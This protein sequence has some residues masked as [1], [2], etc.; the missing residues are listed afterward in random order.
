MT[1]NYK[2]IEEE[3]IKRYGTDDWYVDVLSNMYS[4]KTHFIFELIQNADDAFAE[5]VTIK[6][7]KDRIEFIHN[8]KKLFDEENVRGICGL[9]KG[10]KR[11]SLTQIGKFGLGFKSVYAYTDEP[12][13][14]SGDEAFK[15]V[16]FV[17]PNRIEPLTGLNKN[18]T[19][20][21]L[22]FKENIDKNTAFKEIGVKII[23]LSLRTLLFLRNVKSINWSIEG[24]VPLSGKYEKQ[25]LV[26]TTFNN[27]YCLSSNNKKEYW[28]IFK[29]PV[30]RSKLKENGN[31]DTLYV[32]AA[33]QIELDESNKIKS[34]LS[35]EET[36]LVVFFPT[37]KETHLKFLVQGPYRTTH[38]RENIPP[39]DAWN[40][41]LIR[42]TAELIKKT[43]LEF[44]N[45]NVL[46]SN[47]LEIFP[48]D[49]TLFQENSMFLPFYDT[50][51]KLILSG[52]EILPALK[53]YVG[54]NNALIARG[55]G[56]KELL[57]SSQLSD[58]FDEEN[59]KWLHPSITLDRT[60]LL[61]D[62]L[63]K[64]IEIEVITPEKFISAISEEFMEKQTD[65]WI[66]N[67]YCFGKKQYSLTKEGAFNHKPILR[68]ENNQH[69]NPFDEEDSVQVY[70]PSNSYMDSFFD[71]VKKSLI[72]NAEA[73]SFLKE[74]GLREG[75][76]ILSFRKAILPRYRE[77][78]V[79]VKESDNEKHVKMLKLLMESEPSEELNELISGI[80]ELPFFIGVNISLN[81]SKFCKPKN[82]YIGKDYT[83][84]DELNLYFDGNP[85]IYFLSQSYNSIL[86]LE[87][88]K[89][90]G[91]NDKIIVE[92]K[93]PDWNGYVKVKDY[94]GRHKRGLDGFDPDCS[95]EGLSF[96]IE[97]I[98]IEKARI[99]WT[100]LKKYV[101]SIKGTVESSRY[102]TFSSSE[103]KTANSSMGHIITTNAWLPDKDGNFHKPAELSL[104]EIHN[105]LDKN[106]DDAK[107]L[108]NK[109]MKSA[110]I[111]E[112]IGKLPDDEK[113]EYKIFKS[114]REVLTIDEMLEIIK[115]KT[116]PPKKHPEKTY[117]E[118][119]EKDFSPIIQ[120]DSGDVFF[121][122]I[123]K[124]SLPQ[125]ER[126]GKN[127][128]EIQQAIAEKES[129]EE[130]RLTE[131]TRTPITIS[132]DVKNSLIQEYDGKCQI[133]FERILDRKNSPHL[134]MCRIVVPSQSNL[135]I[136]DESNMLAL[137]PN[138]HL[139]FKLK[140]WNFL[141]DG[142]QSR[143][144]DFN[145]SD[146]KE[147]DD[148]E[149]IRI[150]IILAGKERFIHYKKD[151]FDKFR[152]L[153][154]EH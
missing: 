88:L 96:A 35:T 9:G 49:K 58:L 63:T 95:I 8:G 59:M 47:L 142:V 92:Y 114:L 68:L 115:K 126:E 30:D 76:K 42:L 71:I 151:H 112:V 110:K 19:Y 99:I 15:I 2:D 123:T 82:L 66:I 101:K 103:K 69:K 74:L 140:T 102:T 50:V 128:E 26:N 34:F 124:E 53:G 75:N 129:Q 29:E 138:C 91:C 113:E 94:W 78:E 134:S 23:N 31:N 117:E 41:D 150:K 80:K 121:P 16:K 18:L 56:L 145:N 13:I 43:I 38:N 45:K 149:Y 111:E 36:P 48:I 60:R 125:E 62:Y 24:D 154:K 10:T 57:D 21:K 153:C 3:N 61:W 39:D 132:N 84:S 107:S 72:Q 104:E 67:L 20:F 106:S 51:K 81:K 131:I 122:T 100:Y 5:E 120:E 33:F 65:E 44:K 12:I 105:S 147:I 7:F 54:C 127:E 89:R 85:S 116:E 86:S 17:R 70:L 4:D 146:K 22:P 109:I 27:T 77:I 143:N 93:E 98:T 52:E 28:L 108:A 118:E 46:D 133:C 135:G 130:K 11:D 83:N 97:H 55:E 139:R 141:S 119:L 148:R 37:A 14:Y 87:N 73:K 144:P 64:E 136:S 6:L 90:L 40:R 1:S 25:L 152:Q 32:E 137:C 79:K